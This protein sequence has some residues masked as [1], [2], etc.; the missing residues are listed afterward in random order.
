MKT[1]ILIIISSLFL[2]SCLN[3][4][5]ENIF[6][7]SYPGFHLVALTA[8]EEF[9]KFES[10]LFYKILLLTPLSKECISY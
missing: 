9:I 1:K 2:A 6:G 7:K 10:E 3:G 8:Q 4:L 5:E